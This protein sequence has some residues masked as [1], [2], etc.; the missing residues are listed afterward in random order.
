M[1]T[2]FYFCHYCGKEYIPKRRNF[3]KYCSNSCRTNAFMKRK[4][5]ATVALATTTENKFHIT[6][7]T[8]IDTMSLAGVGNAATGSALVRIAESLLT[9]EIN[10]P[11]TKG[12][13]KNL[14]DKISKRYYLIKNM[15]KDGLGRNPHFDTVQCLVVYF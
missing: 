4:N 12:D 1:D 9:P 2:Y 8:K 10:K 11:A 13:I 14:A 7:P 5:I 6:K 15:Q 3:Q